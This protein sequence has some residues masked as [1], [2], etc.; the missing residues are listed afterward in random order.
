[1]SREVTMVGTSSA[2]DLVLRNKE[3]KAK[4]ICRLALFL[5]MYF[6]C[7]LLVRLRKLQLRRLKIEAAAAF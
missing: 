3:R 7:L 6:F 5:V 2:N 4:R 1:M